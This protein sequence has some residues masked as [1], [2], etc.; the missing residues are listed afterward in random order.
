MKDLFFVS[1]I[2]ILFSCSNSKSS[3]D[4]NKNDSLKMSSGD[5]TAIS[6]GRSSQV[7]KQF[8]II[9]PSLFGMPD[10][11]P[12]CDCYLEIID[13]VLFYRKENNIVYYDTLL[14]PVKDLPYHRRF[15]RH[16][17]DQLFVKGDTAVI[18][19]LGEHGDKEY[20]YRVR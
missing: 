1:A 6:K 5:S 17:Q 20:F 13:S 18:V 7:W 8:R 19:K 10:T 9:S 4:G 14:P 11:L 2:L 16:E 15:Q 3:G 12:P